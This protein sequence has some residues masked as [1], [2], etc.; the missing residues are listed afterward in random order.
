LVDA[1]VDEVA[2]STTIDDIVSDCIPRGCLSRN[3]DAKDEDSDED[4]SVD[5]MLDG[6]GSTLAVRAQELLL[7][8]AVEVMTQYST[9]P[10]QTPL[11]F[12]LLTKAQRA[13]LH[14]LA[15]RLGLAHAS[16]GDDD[17]RV[18]VV[19]RLPDGPPGPVVFP[20]STAPDERD[21][22]AVYCGLDPF[23]RQQCV[24]LDDPSNCLLDY[25]HWHYLANLLLL[26]AT[27]ST[28]LFRYDCVFFVGSCH[29]FFKV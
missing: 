18:L 14:M 23:W 1:D 16:E 5:D 20:R 27:K 6:G 21:E 29:C 24:P 22:L 15:D 25:D 19:Q 8:N 3:L 28:S 2:D 17:T 12:S 10:V 7:T 11:R 9:S 4:D 13:T 26:A